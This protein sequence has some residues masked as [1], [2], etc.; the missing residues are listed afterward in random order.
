MPGEGVRIQLEGHDDVGVSEP[1]LCDLGMDPRPVAAP[2]HGSA[3]GCGSGSPASPAGGRPRERRHWWLPPATAPDHRLRRT[4]AYRPTG[5]PRAAGDLLPAAASARVG[6]RRRRPGARWNAVS[7][8]WGF[9]PDGAGALLQALGDEHGTGLEPEADY[10]YC[11]TRS[12][13]S[14]K[15]PRRRRKRALSC[16][17]K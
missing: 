11:S 14:P 17:N 8:P 2:Q 16:Q 13:H 3:S 10:A 15:L 12:S 1:L 5:G 7:R 6:R 4:P 9:L